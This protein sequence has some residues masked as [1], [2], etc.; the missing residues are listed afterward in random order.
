MIALLAASQAAPVICDPDQAARLQRD[1]RIPM[2]R[3][4]VTQPNL[5]PGL[6]R[7]QADTEV[8]EVL[9]TLCAAGRSISL[10]PAE[11]W[12]TASFSAYSF[13]LTHSRTEGCALMQESAVLTVGVQPNQPLSLGIRGQLPP[14]ITPIGDCETP[15]RYRT[16]T[17]LHGAGTAVL[18]VL[19]TDHSAGT[20][21]TRLVVRRATVTGWQES[22]LLDPAPDRL[23][24]GGSGPR[25]S[26][27]RADGDT[28]IVTHADRELDADTCRSLPGQTVWRWDGADWNALSGREALGRLADRGAWRLAGDDAW[29]L[30]LA[31]DIESDRELLKARMRR[32]Q[33]RHSDPLSIRESASFPE[34]NSGF[35]IVSPDPWPTRE[36]AEAARK[37]WGRR[38]GVYVKRGWQALDA[39]GP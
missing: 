33:R 15:P 24:D 11:S 16:E 3:I 22:P 17:V 12:S 9:D 13:V 4:P 7:A 27:A 32:L 1:A 10:A 25:V 20:E 35:L 5:L 34:M 19:V 28:W 23:I 6:A 21:H 14:S 30:I 38:T 31:Q 29:F 18:L 37:S 8:A 36:E 26:L 2:D 39:C